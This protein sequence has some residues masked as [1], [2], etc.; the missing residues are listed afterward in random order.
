M[1]KLKV[2]KRVLGMV[3]TNV[4]LAVN[5][6][7]KE[8]ILIDPADAAEALERDIAALGVHPVGILLTHGHFDHIGAAEK[9]AERYQ[10]KIGAG[11]EEADV[12]SAAALNLSTQFGR[13]FT[14]SPDC[15]YADKEELLLAGF[16]IQVL[17]TPGHTKGGVCYYLPEEGALFSGDTLFCESVGRT[18]FPTGSMSVLARSVRGLLEALPDETAVYPGHESETTIAHEKE[19]NPFV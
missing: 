13:P 1:G 12:M 5:T 10:I 3:R 14:A 7:T 16:R 15:L 9:L 8:A 6:E 11:S 4:Y 2:E 19:F 17:C 18:D